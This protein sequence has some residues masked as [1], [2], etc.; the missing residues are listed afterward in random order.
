VQ[1]DFGAGNSVQLSAYRIADAT[2]GYAGQTNRLYGA[3]IQGSNDGASWATLDTIPNAPFY[4]RYTMGPRNQRSVSPAV[5]YRYYRFAQ[6]TTYG[7]CSEI[8]WIGPAGASAIAARPVQPVIA[9]GAGV[10]SAGLVRIAIT[11]ATTSASI[12]YTTD[13]SV[14]TNTNGTLY[15]GPFTL[16]VVAAT[17]LQAVAYDSTLASAL[18]DAASAHYRNYAFAANEDW[19]DD[20]GI[21]IE[22]HAPH[23]IGPIQ[24]R[25]YMVGQFANKG[26]A[27]GADIGANEG[28]WMYS[29]ADL[30]NWHFEGQI[31]DNGGSGGTAWNYVERPNILFD[32]STNQ[33]VLW[34]HMSNSHDS[35]DRAG[36]ATAANIRGPWAWQ[37][38]TLNPDNN[39][40]KDFS[41]F[42]DDDGTGYVAYVIGTQGSITI[43]RLRGD[44][45]GTTGS[46]VGGLAA[47]T[48]GPILW[49]RHGTYFLAS[50]STNY[51][52][53]VSGTFNLRYIT[54]SPCS[55]PLG[56][57]NSGYSYLFSPVPT[58]NQP[59]NCQS[60]GILNIPSRQDAFLLL[61]DFYNPTSLYNS[62]Q[63]WAPLTFPNSTT[64]QANTPA[65]WDLT[66]WGLAPKAAISGGT[67][68]H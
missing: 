10:Y 62:R 63:S 3:V 28:I 66:T 25:Y 34:A 41:L 57:W 60:S 53:S 39:G 44:Y 40:F 37:T 32:S 20:D 6:S 59:Y 54:C 9:P 52:N 5:P 4:A 15:A 35:S 31:L 19:Y 7:E 42:Q 16:P 51:Y 48:E 21:L 38:V 22:A 46:S 56:S 33:Y 29:S 64:A 8:Q 1:T 50:S 14:P 43:S 45:Q 55:T 18:S 24:G 61:C 17:V 30:L 58:A 68:F 12:Y 23:I 13:G 26:N 65:V 36:I 27:S 49:K 67:A 11:S 2:P 47:G